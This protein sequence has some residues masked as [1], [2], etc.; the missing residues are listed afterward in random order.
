MPFLVLSSRIKIHTDIHQL[1]FLCSQPFQMSPFFF[2]NS[3]CNHTHS[4]KSFLSNGR[5]KKNSP[6]VT[7][8]SHSSPFTHSLII[9]INPL[10]ICLYMILTNRSSL[11]SVLTLSHTFISTS[12]LSYITSS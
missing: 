6:V 2:S 7:C 8:N 12:Y 10:L 4:M 9:Y 5:W 3:Y 11:S 1:A